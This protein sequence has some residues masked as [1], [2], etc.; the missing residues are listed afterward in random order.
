[1]NNDKE[2]DMEEQSAEDITNTAQQ[3][4]E[5]TTEEI[6][7]ETALETAED[8]GASSPDYKKNKG[9]KKK[10]SGK[11]KAKMKSRSFKRGWA[12]LGITCAVVAAVIVINMIASVLVDKFPAL[13]FD[14]TDSGTYKLSTDTTDYLETLSQDITIQVLA[15]ESEYTSSSSYY[16][17]ANTILKQYTAQSSHIKLEYV[18]LV[19]NPT[20]ANNSKYSSDNLVAGDY[21][22]SCGDKYRVLTKDDQFSLSTD[23]SG[24]QTVDSITVESAVTTAILNVTS[25]DQTKVQIIDGFGNYS[26]SG[27]QTALKNNNYDVSTV[28]LL[29]NEIDENTKMLILFTPSVDLDEAS[30]KKITDYLYNKGEYGKNLMYI[31]S[32]SKADTPVL[33]S[34]LDEWG[35]KMGDGLVME[36]DTD[37][38]LYQDTYFYSTLEYADTTYTEGLKNSSLNLVGGNIRPVEITDENKATAL[39]TT[40]ESAKL[41]P[42]DADDSFSIDDA[43]AQQFNAATLSTQYDD[44]QEKNSHVAVFGS[45]I[46][47]DDSALTMS[48]YN[49]SAYVINLTNIL[50]D[51]EDVGITIEG[52]SQT[53]NQLGIVASQQQPISI[54]FV[55]VIPLA[56]LICGLV[57]WLRRRNK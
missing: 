11:L 38:L 25:E 44:K 33:D 19:A 3:E 36:T 47:F 37:H 20:F 50:T 26:C 2:K 21:I 31:A 23:S 8:S 40:T 1:M 6:T 24:N 45:A 32:P 17:Q 4:T 15:N 42:Y 39:L 54:I 13:A 18:D 14:M 43:K 46:I 48:S 9:K 49:N 12:A 5:E 28:T 7:D 55:V 51:S 22:V 52:K 56:I 27:L 53:D 29:T 41:L 16:L 35:V 30:A 10:G 57:I 34:I